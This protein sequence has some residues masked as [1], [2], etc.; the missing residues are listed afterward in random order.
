[1]TTELDAELGPLALEVINEFGK[2]ITITSIA[3]GDIDTATD[4]VA[5]VPTSVAVRAI[6]EDYQ[7]KGRHIPE[8]AMSGQ[9]YGQGF[10]RAGSK[11]ITVAALG[12]TEPQPGDTVT[13]D[14]NTYSVIGVET[15]YSGDLAC[16][17]IL[18]C[19]ST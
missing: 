6:V 7:L 12:I 13:V 9:D 16:L 17:Y 10:L 15:V 1:M 19:A 5:L 2:L 8:S 11:K 3:A 18:R 4:T 14:A